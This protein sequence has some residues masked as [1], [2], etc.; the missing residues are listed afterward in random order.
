[1]KI[2]FLVTYYQQERFVRESMDSILALEKPPEWEILI[3]DDGSTDGTVSVAQSYVDQDPEHVRLFIMDRDRNR[4]YNAVERASANRLN[5]VK[6]AT[7]DC[8]CLMDGDDFYSET[9][10]IP[11]AISLLETHPEVNV[12]GFGT[13]VYQDGSPIR[14]KKGGREKPVS[15]QRERY[16][17]WQY[18]HA[19]ACVIRNDHT[20]E[21]FTLLERLGSFDDNDIVLNALSRG[22]MIRVF[23]PVYAYRQ[24][25][26][27]VYNAMNLSEK[28]ALNVV[29]MGVGLQIMGPE[30]EKCISARSCTAVWM[31]WLLRK[32]LPD[33]LPSSKYQSYLEGCRRAE[34]LLGEQLLRFREL[35]QDKQREIRK[36]VYRVGMECP[37]RV[38]YACLQVSRRRGKHE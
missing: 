8:Y 37:L 18:T 21:N 6:H 14:R 30:W 36:W 13:W 20:S 26:A 7:G 35:E 3:G 19:G 32:H 5:L 24:V 9:D 28:A 17:R 22:E 10:F 12:I 23:R 29:G 31:A 1:M 4:K 27:S 38:M 2:S 33:D 25:N 34:F 16:L 11:E 15:I